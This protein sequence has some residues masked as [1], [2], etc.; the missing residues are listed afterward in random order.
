MKNID[1]PF[2][3]KLIMFPHGHS[4]NQ[5]EHLNDI[6]RHKFLILGKL[7]LKNKDMIRMK[8]NLDNL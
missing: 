2:D 8:A 7:A 3:S 4:K 1:E 5:S 6:L